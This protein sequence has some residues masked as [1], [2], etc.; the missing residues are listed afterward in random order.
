ML[1]KELYSSEDEFNNNTRNGK[2]IKCYKNG[3]RY[4]GEIK[5]NKYRFYNEIYEF[6]GAQRLDTI[7]NDDVHIRIYKKSIPKLEN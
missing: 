3:E 5:D 6:L 2:G 7:K 1:K 4:E